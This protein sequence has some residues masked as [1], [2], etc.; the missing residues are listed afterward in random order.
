MECRIAFT[1]FR[2][3]LQGLDDLRCQFWVNTTMG[4]G[5][6]DESALWQNHRAVGS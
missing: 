4:R 6:L 3:D 5:V 1:P 2:I